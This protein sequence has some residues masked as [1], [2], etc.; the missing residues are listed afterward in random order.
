ML[1]TEWEIGRREIVAD[2]GIVAAKHPGA[3]AAGLFVLREG[4]NAVDAAVATAAALNVVEPFMSGLGGDGYMLLY[5]ARDRRLR[6]LDY[7]AAAPTPPPPPPSPTPTRRSAA[8]S[9]P[10]SPAPPAAG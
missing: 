9:R 7:V 8:R 6:A 2:H 3:A 5:T 1:T 4:G 10:S